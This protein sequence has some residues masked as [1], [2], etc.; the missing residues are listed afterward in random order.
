MSIAMLDGFL[1]A[2]VIGPEV[3]MPSDYLPR[4]WDWKRGKND[5]EFED[6]D[7]AN[8][9]LGYIQRMHNRVAGPLMSE[10]SATLPLFILEPHRDHREW[11]GGFA[12]GAEF[13]PEVWD[14]AQDQSPTLFEA[15]EVLNSMEHDDPGRVETFAGVL[16]SIVA[17][18]D[19]FRAG[20]WRQARV[21]RR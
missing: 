12:M 8:R 2:I 14:Y 3:V 5:V 6:L 1:T 7:E 11:L 18:R 13:D 20:E 4:V 21:R 9:I 10:P 15:F 17:L 16:V 19:Y